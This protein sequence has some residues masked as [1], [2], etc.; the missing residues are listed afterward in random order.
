LVRRRG[1]AA[2]NSAGFARDRLDEF[3]CPTIHPVFF[4]TETQPRVVSI[5]LVDKGQIVAGV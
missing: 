4:S 3:F 1:T 5:R 2:F